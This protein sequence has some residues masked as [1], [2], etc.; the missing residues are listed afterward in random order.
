MELERKLAIKHDYLHL[1]MSNASLAKKYGIHRKTVKECLQSQGV[2]LR[3]RTPKTSV[4]HFFFSEYNAISC[5]WAGFILADGYIRTNRR[6]NLHIKLQKQDV[7]HL[8]K[9]KSDIEFCGRI[10]E[11]PDYFSISISSSQL[12][13]DLADKFEIH[14]NKSLTCRISDKIPSEY[15]KDYIRGYFDGDGC[16][17]R[18][19]I[20]AISFTGTHKT[21]SFIRDYFHDVCGIRMRSKNKPDITQKKGGKISIIQYSGKSAF[22]CLKHMYDG[23]KT[24]LERKFFKY[25]T[26]IPKYSIT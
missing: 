17:T 20:E 5:Y 22:R 16:I 9:F 19:S 14:N 10:L 15:L 8:E 25:R 4:N 21:T 6:F 11:Y 24:F 26:W 12:L 23:S 2:K 1:F 18:T 7:G 13:F 3:T